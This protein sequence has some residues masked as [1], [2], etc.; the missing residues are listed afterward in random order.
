MWTKLE[1]DSPQIGEA[2]K[3]L[4]ELSL[5]AKGPSKH[6]VKDLDE[7]YGNQLWKTLSITLVVT[8]PAVWFDA[9]KDR[10][11][12]AVWKA[13]FDTSGFPNLKR[14]VTTTE[15]EAAAIDTIQFLRGSVSDE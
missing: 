2:A 12:Q 8:V 6:V 7:R 11:L 13:G 1:L 5:S 10:T 4:N 9:A 3:I 15:P 14:I